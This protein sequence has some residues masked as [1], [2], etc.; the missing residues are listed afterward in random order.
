MGFVSFKCLIKRKSNPVGFP[1]NFGI[2]QNYLTANPPFKGNEYIPMIGTFATG[3]AY[4]GGPLMTPITLRLHNYRRHMVLFG[5]GL[6]ILGVGG[7]SFATNLWE[8]V[9]CQGI[10][11]GLG[12]LVVSY[13]VFSQLNEWFVERRGLAYGIQLSASGIGGLI[14]P[15]FLQ[16]LLFSS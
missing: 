7:A 2:L 6:C 16:T 8:I 15:F 4:L 5:V 1:L 11:Y 3:I 10:L 12:F 14:L 9:L 13:V